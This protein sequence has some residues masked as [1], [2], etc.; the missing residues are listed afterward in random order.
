MQKKVSTFIVI[1]LV[2]FL[3]A[4]IVWGSRNRRGEQGS[5]QSSTPL[6]YNQPVL[7]YGATCKYCEQLDQWL[8]EE[9]VADYL[10]IERKE[11]FEN[12]DNYVELIQA[13]RSCQLD[14]TSVGVPFLY[15][16]QQCFIGPE[17]I[18]TYLGQQL[19]AVKNETEAS[20]STVTTE[21]ISATPSAV[22]V[23]SE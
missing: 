15:A 23:E 21:E 5:D 16:E 1:A 4:G 13:A 9:K 8:E 3:L 12:E 20:D 10:T 14:V 2:I 11:V 18:I 19:S 7:F 22:G 6:S 17:P